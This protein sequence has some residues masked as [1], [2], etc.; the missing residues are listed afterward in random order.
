LDGVQHE[1]E[2]EAGGDVSPEDMMEEDPLVL[3]KAENDP[4]AE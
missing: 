3:V 2:G 4:E 1:S